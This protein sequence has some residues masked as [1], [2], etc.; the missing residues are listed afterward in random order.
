MV[1][2]AGQCHRCNVAQE[3]YLESSS[4]KLCRLLRHLL[5]SVCCL[6]RQVLQFCDVQSWPRNKFQTSSRIFR[7]RIDQL[8]PVMKSRDSLLISAFGVA[9]LIL[10]GIG[11]LT[12]Q[13]TNQLISVQDRVSAAHETLEQLDEILAQA[14]R[15]ESA[16]RGYVMSG[17]GSYLATR[18]DNTRELGRTVERLG[19]SL[20]GDALQ[21]GRLNQ[22]RALLDQKTRLQDQRV[23]VRRRQGLRPALE[24]FLSGQGN[25]I[26][27]EIE[28]IADQMKDR[29]KYLLQQRR[30]Q[31]RAE[32]GVS[33]RMLVFGSLLSFLILAGVY[34][35]L[36]EEIGKRRVSERKLVHS[37]RLYAL[38]SQ[39][40]QAIVR[41]REPRHLL[42]EVARVSIEYGFFQFAWLGLWDSHTGV[43]IPAAWKAAAARPEEDAS[44][45]MDLGNGVD[46]LAGKLRQGHAIVCNDT[47][48]EDCSESMRTQAVTR[49]YAAAAV[50]PVRVAGLWSGVFGLY[51]S[52]AG[53]F[54]EKVVSLLHEVAS[55]V[56]YALEAIDKEK[57]R[58]LAEEAL[59]KQAQMIDQVHDAIVSTDLQGVVTSWNKGAEKLM[60]YPPAEVIGR[61]ISLMYPPEDRDFL[62]NSVIEPLQRNGVHDIEVRMRKK[63]GED[64]YA[65]LSLALQQDRE[66]TPFG[67]IGYSMDVT[68]T[69]QS[70]LA[71]RQSEERFREMAETVSEAFWLMD[72]Q[73]S[74]VL[75]L[76]PGFEG[77]WGRPAENASGR[78]I[79]KLEDWVLPE[80]R[81]IFARSLDTMAAGESFSE[82]FRI[83]RPDGGLRW[84]W[85]QA[86]PIRDKAGRVY[87]FAGICQDV[88]DRK[89]AEKELTAHVAQQKAVAEMGQCALEATDLEAFLASVMDLTA[90]T[91]DVEFAKLLEF[92]PDANVFRLRAGVGWR[93]QGPVWVPGDAE[94]QAG[95]TLRNKGP[96][97]VTDFLAETRFIPPELLR[98]HNVVSGMSVVVGDSQKPFGVLGVHSIRPRAFTGDD[99]HFL[100]AIANLLAAT[101]ER[102]Q[103]EAEILRLN[104]ELEQRVAKRTAELAD[105]NRQ[106]EARNRDVERANRLKSEFLASMSH[107]VRTP[108]NA[109]I[110]FSDL[111]MREKGG[112]LNETHRRYVTHVQTASRHLL[113]LINDVLDLSKIEAGRLELDR[114]EF[115]VMEALQEVLS[116][117]RPL[118]ANKSIGIETRVPPQLAVYAE[119]TRFKQI[120]FN[121]ISNAVKFT[122]EQGRVWIESSGGHSEVTLSVSDTGIGIPLEEQQRIFEEF[123]Q[124]SATTRGVKEGTGLGLAITKRLVE[125]HGGRIWTV[126]ELGQGS[127]FTFTLPVDSSVSLQGRAQAAGSDS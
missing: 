72:A 67:M 19:R 27:N 101:L 36:T 104:A 79:R 75:Y 23:D 108:L 121:L 29:E 32:A 33:L 21:L 64:F 17:D 124:A 98:S 55:D 99:A 54:D 71:L 61:H 66:G 103:A 35:S 16:I 47:R 30:D 118:A 69:R 90:R 70:E 94:S 25:A 100:Q 38:L 126:S 105:V 89:A 114:R 127:R 113:Q 2:V 122:P 48:S 84:I 12:Y 110:G 82:E 96:V 58:E 60:G 13:N 109:I 7:A 87:R 107:E 74:E 50:F 56:S 4:A 41:T 78:P 37:N 102:R 9:L 76:S 57:Q 123:H 116:V 93:T 119:R 15:A 59:R 49:G 111:L 125:L 53:V 43:M 6:I 63:S 10:C 81:R 77:I 68:K 115:P 40:N 39:A 34:Y 26:T 88:T 3:A 5:E 112:P 85:Q 42:E 45:I 92:M 62:Q 11:V 8:L 24:A 80:D 95:Y 97:V 52:E 120:L 73:S 22:L 117:V 106:L 44:G 28:G 20:R 65:H 14:L 1:Q 91:L 31:A 18:G 86:F 46:S 83:V 51:A